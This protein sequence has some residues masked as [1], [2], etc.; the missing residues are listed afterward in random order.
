[1]TLSTGL[2]S[3]PYD[4][5]SLLSFEAIPG[6]GCTTAPS[7]WDSHPRTERGKQNNGP[8]EVPNLISGTCEC[9]KSHGTRELRLQMEL[10]VLLS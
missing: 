6:W 5:G 4:F 10:G 9:V 7:H 1:M 3:V 8:K 2:S